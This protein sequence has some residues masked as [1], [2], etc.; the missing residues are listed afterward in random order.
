MF[1]AQL[2]IQRNDLRFRCQCLI[3]EEHYRP[4][5]RRYSGARCPQTMRERVVSVVGLTR[6][7][8]GRG[9]GFCG[10]GPRFAQKG[11][12]IVSVVTIVDRQEGAGDA[13][14][15]AGLTLTP[16]LTLTDFK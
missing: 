11:A 4:V 1:V 10:G 5:A 7:G 9:H 15:A 2:A 6:I 12:D 14:T 16:L 8:W 13:F 3:R